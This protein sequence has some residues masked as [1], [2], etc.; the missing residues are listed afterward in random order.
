MTERITVEVARSADRESL[1]A[2][3]RE[4]GLEA[5]VTDDAAIEI[6]CGQGAKRPCGEIVGELEAW[7]VETGLPLVPEPLE[8]RIVLRPPGS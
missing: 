3:L 2:A 6:P 1:L 5:R 7:I 4:R 8:D